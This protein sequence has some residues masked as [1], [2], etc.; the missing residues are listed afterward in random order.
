MATTRSRAQAELA[1]QKFG[2]LLRVERLLD[3]KQEELQTLIRGLEESDRN[4]Y[5]SETEE[6][7]RQDEEL[8]GKRG[9]PAGR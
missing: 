9:L 5:V 6:M 7:R 4:F 2:E 1:I 3:K 8:R